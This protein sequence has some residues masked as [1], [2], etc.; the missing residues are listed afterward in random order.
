MG[1][2][3]VKRGEVKRGENFIGHQSQTIKFFPQEN[4]LLVI[5]FIAVEIEKHICICAA[6]CVHANLK[7]LEVKLV[8]L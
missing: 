3:D 7:F 1:G 4:V 2:G 5:L 6:Q 8:E